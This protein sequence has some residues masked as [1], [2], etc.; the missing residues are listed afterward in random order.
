MQTYTPEQQTQ[1]NAA[2][3]LDGINGFYFFVQLFWNV[4]EPVRFQQ[5]DYLEGICQHMQHVF[6]VGKLLCN[7]PPRHGVSKVISCMAPAWWIA[8]DP[9]LRFLLAS[10]SKGVSNGFVNE[11]RKIIESPLYKVM[12]PKVQLTKTQEDFLET[13]RNGFIKSVS[14]DSGTLS[15]GGNCIIFDDPNDI[16]QINSQAHCKSVIEYWEQTLKTRINAGR[17][18]ARVIVQQRC[19]F[20]DLTQHL[21][22]NDED[23]HHMN[24]P[25]EA[26]DQTYQSK[27]W[28]DKRQ[29]GE[30]LSTLLS[31]NELKDR[32]R[33]KW[34]WAT[35]YNQKPRSREGQVFTKLNYYKMTPQGDYQCGDV[36]IPKGEIRKF[37]SS[38][39]AISERSTADYTVLQ[40]WGVWQNYLILLFQFRDRINSVKMLETFGTIYHNHDLMFMGVE[41]VAFQRMAIQQLRSKG[42]TIKAFKPEGDKVARTLTAQIKNDCGELWVGEDPALEDEMLAFPNGRH[43]DMVDA[44]SMAA[45][46]AQKYA[47]WK[48]KPPPKTQEEVDA[49]RIEWEHNAQRA[50]M[51]EG[52]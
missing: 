52:T 3:C 5:Q 34:V 27:W 10:Y 28:N 45:L 50:M 4:I 15:E 13:S 7:K 6:D 42:L 26:D 12:F 16:K 18:G 49:E 48:P 43:D 33:N 47:K 1:L 40:V 36:I 11:A 23:W 14:I 38:D 35:Q 37:G 31:P 9:T 24:L 21:L 29:P 32:Q 51:L 25:F 46:L 22:D 17:R 19:G 39:L 41:D 20:T 2:L 8:K 44:C 30:K